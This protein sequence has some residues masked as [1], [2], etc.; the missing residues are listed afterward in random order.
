MPTVS[1]NDL[2]CASTGILKK[3]GLSHDD[4]L[5]VAD[6]IKYANSHGVPTHGAG[7]LPLYEKNITAGTMDPTA[8]P[9]VVVD[10][11]AIGVI[12]GHNALGQVAAKAAM[13]LALRKVKE[14]GAAVVA[15]RNS[16]NFGTA[17]FYGAW[18]ARQ[19][20]GAIIM[21]NASP[22]MAPTGGNR[23]L[24]GTNPICMSMPGVNDNPP[25]VLDMATTVVARTKIR[26]AA[27]EGMP[28][29]GD[30][31]IDAEGNSTTDASKALDGTLLPIGGYKGYGLSLFVD[32][33]A[34]MLAQG[35]FGGRVVPLSDLS[36]PSRNGHLFI[37]FD[38]FR[39]MDATTYRDSY[40]FFAAQ[41]ASCGE[42]ARLPGERG[43]S[44]AASCGGFVDITKKQLEEINQLSEKLGI[45]CM[46]EV[47]Q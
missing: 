46:K 28:I 14:Y 42:G 18:A 25:I 41:V 40:N 24:F 9:E 35:A 10:D 7:R 3:L 38:V 31:A 13:E 20:C 11:C 29:P 26:T 32:L 43:F 19:G 16:N 2:I 39:F 15:V 44:E 37:L 21:A 17:G 8:V 30:W 45:R 34:G 36:A 4:A 27:K 23:A 33:F 6:T 1:L 22:A 5:A 47:A 12:D